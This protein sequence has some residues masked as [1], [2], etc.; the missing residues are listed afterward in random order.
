M[1][2]GVQGSY[3]DSLERKNITEPFPISPV[4]TQTAE[5]AF[6]L[7]LQNAG[8]F[9]PA[10]D[11]IDKRIVEETRTGTASFGESYE[12]GVKDY[13]FSGSKSADGPY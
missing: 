6:E 7:V 3:A 10:R 12:G 5:E 4:T 2:R 13:R 9:F 11:E 8:A 1:E